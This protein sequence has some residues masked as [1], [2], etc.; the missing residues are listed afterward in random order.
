MPYPR[1]ARRHDFIIKRSARMML[2]LRHSEN[3]SPKNPVWILRYAQDDGIRKKAPIMT[4][5][6]KRSKNGRL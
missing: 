4:V 5:S 1:K 2:F 6:I 3:V